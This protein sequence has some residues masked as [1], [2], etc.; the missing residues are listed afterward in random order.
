MVTL[1]LTEDKRLQVK[2]ATQM[3]VGENRFEQI[4]ILLPP[5]VCGREII[6]YDM[7]LHVANVETKE[8][9]TYALDPQPGKS[10]SVATIEVGIDLT[11]KAQTLDLSLHL[12]KDDEVGITNPVQ[13]TISEPVTEQQEIIPRS[14]LVQRVAELEAETQDKSAQI[15]GLTARIAAL[16]GQVTALTE[17][18]AVLEAEIRDLTAQVTALQSEV[19]AL[20]TEKEETQAHIAELDVASAAIENVL[21]GGST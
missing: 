20:T 19:D 7:Q 8:Y 15:S 21:Q 14:V 6:N 1:N 9:F 16:E 4:R 11:D 5:V 13:V 10:G 17:N 12:Q 2:S 18:K 3:Y